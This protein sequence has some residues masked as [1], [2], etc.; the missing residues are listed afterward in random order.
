MA[1]SWADIAG[2]IIS[3]HGDSIAC[4]RS[5]RARSAARCATA[6]AKTGREPRPLLRV[7]VSTQHAFDRDLCLSTTCRTLLLASTATGTV[8]RF[9]SCVR[10]RPLAGSNSLSRQHS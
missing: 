2:T 6:L 7:R 8:A 10:R 9:A 1:L 4:V 3:L 5:A